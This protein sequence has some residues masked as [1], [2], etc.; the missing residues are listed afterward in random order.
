MDDWKNGG[1]ANFKL[2]KNLT[3]EK[4]KTLDGD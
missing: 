4:E 1:R 2:L 3:D